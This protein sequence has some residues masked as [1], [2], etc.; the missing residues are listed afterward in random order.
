MKTL[1]QFMKIG[2]LFG[3][4]VLLVAC[5]QDER[6]ET[7]EPEEPFVEMD[8]NGHWTLRD[9]RIAGESVIELA[10]N[11][12]AMLPIDLDD[13]TSEEAGAREWAIDFY[14]DEG[15]LTIVTQEGDSIELDY[16]V[17]SR[18]EENRQMMVDYTW[19]D[20]D[21]ELV[22]NETMTFSK[23][24]ESISTETRIEAIDAV[25]EKN[26]MVEFLQGLTLEL[27]L[28]YVNDARTP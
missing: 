3:L 5:G 18:D 14:Y 11:Y 27:E 23:D 25:D 13:V 4:T 12:E 24:G 26:N 8:V 16:E 15:L 2:L 10:E 21:A 22:L 6:E 7:A 1:K 19:N 20:H 9:A 28:D 17:L